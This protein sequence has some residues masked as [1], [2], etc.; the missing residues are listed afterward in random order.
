MDLIDCSL[1]PCVL[2]KHFITFEMW[3]LRCWGRQALGTCLCV[4]AAETF[5]DWQGR[6]SS[7]LGLQISGL[8][9][10]ACVTQGLLCHSRICLGILFTSLLVLLDLALSSVVSKLCKAHHIYT[11][12]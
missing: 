10:V 5:A 12:F 7:P 6:G 1:C 11:V 3:I 2:G 4:Y 8:H 9:G